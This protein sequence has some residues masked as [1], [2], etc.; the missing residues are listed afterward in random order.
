VT[1]LHEVEASIERNDNRAVSRSRLLLDSDEAARSASQARIYND[2]GFQQLALVEGWKSVNTDP[3]EASAHRFLADNYAALP[4]H[5]IA[6]VSELLQSQMFDPLNLAPIQPRAAESSLGQINAAGPATASASEF[7]SLFKRNQTNVFL[8]ATGAELGTA[9]GDVVVGGIYDAWSFSVG[10]SH[11]N[12]DGFRENNDQKDNFGNVFVQAAVSPDTSVQFEY[13]YRKTESGDLNLH[14][15]ETFSPARRSEAESDTYRV[16]LRQAFS[17]N[18][19]LLVSVQRKLDDSSFSD[20]PVPGLIQFGEER[21]DNKALGIELR[22]LYRATQYNIN[23][24]AGY[25]DLDEPVITTQTDPFLCTPPCVTP[26]DLSAKHTNG[27]VYSDI[28][29]MPEVTLALGASVDFFDTLDASTESQDQVNPKLGVTWQAQPGTTLRA[30]GFRVLTRSLVT[31]QTLEPTQVAGFNQF[32]N[33]VASTDAWRYGVA[34][35]QK[36]S[37]MVFGGVELSQRDLTVPINISIPS[38]LDIKTEQDWEENLGRAYL[39]MTPTERIGLSVEYL[40]E[41]LDRPFALPGSATSVSE[42]KAHK[43]PLGIRYFSPSGWT[44]DVKGTFVR[45]KVNSGDVNNVTKQTSDFWLA[46]AAVSYRLPRRRGFVSVGATNLFDKEFAYEQLNE[47]NTEMR[48]AR[49]SY[50]RVTLYLP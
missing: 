39:F 36:F 50:A 15:D 10:G 40:Y 34:L 28:R 49:M 25:V 35:D 42:V 32:Y 45:E 27:Y 44:V 13:R 33:D 4:R 31:D 48:P 16:G 17:P 43:A 9:S 21:L 18:S 1:A 12:T 3:G 24:G 46:D 47:L 22:H 23:T 26:S 14:I 29:V 8:S 19:I 11:F 6:R 7:N 41:R 2:L 37:R 5:E 30:A 20:E 38:I